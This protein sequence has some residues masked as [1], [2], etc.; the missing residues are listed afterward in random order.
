MSTRSSVVA[1]TGVEEVKEALG[2]LCEKPYKLK[3]KFLIFNEADKILPRA[4]NILLKT[5]EEPPEHAVVLLLSRTEAGLLDTVT[6]RCRKIKVKS[7]EAREE[8]TED[9]GYS[10]SKVAT[11]DL[12]KNIE[13]VENLAKEDREVILE[14]LGEWV[15]GVRGEMLKTGRTELADLIGVISGIQS[16]LENTNVGAR[17]ALEQV[18]LAFW[19]NR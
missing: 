18:A 11:N 19:R 9:T 4:Q 7:G 10:Y 3:S 15:G 5:L 8:K 2:F 17:L 13:L 16:D 1:N 6:S 14:T 12:E